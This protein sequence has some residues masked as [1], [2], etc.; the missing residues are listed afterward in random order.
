VTSKLARISRRQVAKRLGDG[1][2]AFIDP[3]KLEW[4]CQTSYPYRKA[5][6]KAGGAVFNLPF[7]GR[8]SRKLIIGA[9][10]FMTPQHIKFD[11]IRLDHH[12]TYRKINDFVENV[13]RYKK[14]AWHAALLEELN[15]E[16]VARH[17]RLV[18]YSPVDI[19][20]FF[21][22]YAIPL[23]RS[24]QSQGIV[25]STLRDMPMVHILADG[26][27][28]KGDAGNHRVALARRLDLKRIPVHIAGT[29][30]DW[31]ESFGPNDDDE[32]L[33]GSLRERVQAVCRAYA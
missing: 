5:A 16:G 32:D 27:L 4:H 2:V 21:E 22:T 7:I 9:E 6:L 28:A 8:M 31:I 18:M 3:G 25:K 23:F 14:S 13:H 24:I 19:E 1:C 12:P 11:K 20:N 15:R 26:T 17:K 10:P 29:H 33:F 30:Q